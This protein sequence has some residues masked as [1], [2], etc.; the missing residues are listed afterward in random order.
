MTADAGIIPELAT[1]HADGTAP[2]AARVRRR[3]A[4][5]STRVYS[6]IREEILCL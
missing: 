3:R 4:S 2:R 5:G 6:K 1:D